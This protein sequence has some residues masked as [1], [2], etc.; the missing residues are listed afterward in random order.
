MI[1][2]CSESHTKHINT[3]FR[4]KAELLS[5]IAG[6]IYSYFKG[7]KIMIRDDG[8]NGWSLETRHILNSS[9]K[10]HGFIEA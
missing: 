3:L 7:V 6:G 9:E 5:C 1:A 10:P 4:Q 8:E 2:V